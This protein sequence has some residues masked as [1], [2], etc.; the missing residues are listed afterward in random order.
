MLIQE[1]SGK[2]RFILEVE[3]ID[4]RFRSMSDPM[5]FSRARMTGGHPS[6]S[7]ALIQIVQHVGTYP[8][9]IRK[10]TAFM[11]ASKTNRCV[12]DIGTLT[13]RLIDIEEFQEALLH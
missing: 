7:F 6:G 8:V 11:P 2:S 4:A 3:L 9:L 12:V 5:C 10:T 13:E 1:L